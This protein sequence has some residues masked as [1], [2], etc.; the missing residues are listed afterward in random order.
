M[1]FFTEDAVTFDLAPPPK[2]T[3][4][5]LRTLEG[6]SRPGTAA[7]ATSWR[8]GG[9]GERLARGIAQP[10]DSPEWPGNLAFGI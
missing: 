7:S 2:H 3:G 5:D 4:F 8:P 6:C 9:A 1:R 10:R